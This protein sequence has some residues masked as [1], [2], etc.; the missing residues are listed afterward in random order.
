FP[1]ERQAKPRAWESDRNGA[2]TGRGGTVDA[3][4]SGSGLLPRPLEIPVVDFLVL[5]PPCR[6]TH[7]VEQG[8]EWMR[9]QFLDIRHLLHIP[10]ARGDQHG[11]GSRRNAGGIGNALTTY[12][13]ERFLVIGNII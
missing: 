13:L 9:R 11:G 1:S 4:V 3:A 12:L 8:E 2:A 6:Q 5:A 10:F 7:P